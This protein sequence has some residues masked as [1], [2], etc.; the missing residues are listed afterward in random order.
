MPHP[1][2]DRRTHAPPGT[3]L[4]AG[5]T[6]EQA[7][8]VTHGTGPLVVAEVNG[9]RGFPVRWRPVGLLADRPKS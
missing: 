9:L 1:E 2:P 8:A 4:L 7:R 3:S 6:A 5:L